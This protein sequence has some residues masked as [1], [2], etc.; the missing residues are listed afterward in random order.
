METPL[1]NRHTDVSEIK[2]RLMAYRDIDRD[3]D[4][5]IERIENL[6]AKMCSIGSPELSDMPKSP[7]TVGDRLASQ[8]ALKCEMEDKVR[9]LIEHRDEE[10]RW[11]EGVLSHIKNPD[12]RAVI[13]MRYIDVENWPDV[14]RMLFGR[15]VDYE[16]RMES[17]LRRTTKL[18]GRALVSMAMAVAES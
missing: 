17:Y 5:Q 15:K 9:S 6:E 3:I 8:I 10:R 12:E 4:N 11:I 18:H 1:E 14:S 2:K 16:D 13:E 7:N